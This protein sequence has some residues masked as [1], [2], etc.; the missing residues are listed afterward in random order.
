MRTFLINPGWLFSGEGGWWT[1]AFSGC[2][3]PRGYRVAAGELFSEVFE[4]VFSRQATAAK[5][6]SA[7]EGQ[8]TASELRARYEWSLQLWIR[9]KLIELPDASIPEF[10]ERLK[11]AGNALLKKYPHD[12]PAIVLQRKAK[13]REELDTDAWLRIRGTL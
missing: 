2:T 1:R 8:L 6:P 4:R 3:R 5:K 11:E 13:Y 12:R 9:D 10:T 7:S